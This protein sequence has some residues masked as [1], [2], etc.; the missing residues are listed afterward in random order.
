M[1]RHF[2][3][4]SLGED[5]NSAVVLRV[6]VK[7]GDT[8][9]ADDIVIELETDKATTEVPCPF[10]G[11]VEA[12]EVAEGETVEAG[13]RVLTV[14]EE[15]AE[16]RDEAERDEDAD[17]DAAERGDGGGREE[18]EGGG[19]RRTR[20]SDESDDGGGA[21]DGGEGG[22]RS[23][24]AG[25]G[26]RE[27]SS[28]GREES[29]DGARGASGGGAGGKSSSGAGAKS[30]GGRRDES[31]D[32]GAEARD[33]ASGD[34]R[35]GAP[36]PRRG[37]PLAAP[38]V[39]QLARE[40]GVAV[41]DVPGTGADGRVDAEDVKS[42]VRRTLEDLRARVP[43]RPALPDLAAYGAHHREPLGAVRRA[44]ADGVARSWREVP[45]VTQGDLADVTALRQFRRRAAD[46]IE[47][48]GGG[49]TLTAIV[50]AVVARAL[51]EFPRFNAAIDLDR[52]EA[53]LFEAVH[54]GVAVDTPAGLLV[55]VLRD[56]DRKGLAE[57]SARLSVLAEKAR[58]RALGADALE[59]ATF[60]VTNLGGLGTTS[61]T[62]IVPWPQVAILGI[63]RARTR[64]VWRDERFE[65]RELMPLSLSYDHR[66]VDGAD[67]ARFLRWIAG[68]LEDPLRLTLG[69]PR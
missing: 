24:A 58:D 3:L 19:G 63:G 13:Q 69:A 18:D 4:P 61:F 50:L 33:G 38:S 21:R 68:A 39:R 32:G 53:V 34:R 25:G 23:G 59:G 8:L 66:A 29:S 42:H 12:V 45:H 65:P 16:D 52:H 55:P 43:D 28:G 22:K 56:A 5:T 9:E 2:E 62:P 54:L 27:E 1:A 26:A 47:A 64:P 37:A 14:R 15:G 6:L 48:E 46:E 10:G 51:H 44:I 30:S 57:I 60:T 49:L 11:V 31:S 41:E 20:G 36:G 40:L 17:D 67:A 7:A 35:P